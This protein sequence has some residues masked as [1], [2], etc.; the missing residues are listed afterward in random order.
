MNI[1]ENWPVVWVD[2]DAAFARLADSWRRLSL[3]AIDT[4]FERQT[5]YYPI[6]ALVQVFDG[7]TVYL[8]DPLKVECPDEFRQI[9]ANRNI[10]KVMHSAREDLE[11]FYYS[12]QCRLNGL[13]DTQIAYAFL[14]GEISKGYAALVAD[15]CQ[16]SIDKQE[17]RSD[18]T[19]RPLSNA[20]LDYA[21]KD[22]IYLPAL[23]EHLNEAINKT[24]I[25]ELF[26]KECDELCRVVQK[27]PDYDTDYRMAKEVWKLGKRQLSLFRQLYQWREQTG[28]KDNRTVNHIIKDPQLVQIAISQPN[29]KG[30]LFKI[31][32]LHPKSIRLYWSAISE[33]IKAFKNAS[34]N[35][36][37]C[38]S[39]PREVEG[40][41]QLCD[42]LTKV[43]KSEAARL[44]LAANLLAS[45]RQVKKI[46][47]AKLTGEKFPDL[48]DGWRGDILKPAFEPVFSQMPGA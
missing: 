43:V 23:Y 39:N 27:K 29:S 46:A 26:V 18:W 14:H 25:G 33:L 30:E 3:L 47:F 40:L 36:L 48:W 13:F 8:I 37:V 2:S 1:P 34:N 16:Q 15:V 28:I 41:K 9:C 24:A 20:Q 19:K 38:V 22:V 21:S 7:K 11:V 42:L 31:A 6:L 35:D 10:V 12:W 32:D 5:T 44:G 45:K 4:E 17:T